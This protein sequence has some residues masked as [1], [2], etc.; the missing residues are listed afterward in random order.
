MDYLTFQLPIGKVVPL[1]KIGEG[2]SGTVLNAHYVKPDG[3]IS[4]RVALKI[5]HFYKRLEL[6]NEIKMLQVVSSCNQVQ[7]LLCFGPDPNNIYWMLI[8][9]PVGLSL[10]FLV[11]LNGNFSID[12]TIKVTV[13]I[14]KA[15]KC[16]HSLNIIHRDIKPGNIICGRYD[17]KYYLIDFGIAGFVDVEDNCSNYGTPYFSPAVF[18]NYPKYSFSEDIQS[19]FFCVAFLVLGFIPWHSDFLVSMKISKANFYG[20]YYRLFEQS[21]EKYELNQTYFI[22]FLH[23]LINDNKNNHDITD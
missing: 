14:L 18:K 5:T 6:E 15:L 16:I 1:Y 7:K 13:D 2:S 17:K 3:T 11:Q 19:L 21:I 10:D 9:E 8:T 23:K 22:S 20:I 12:E 4:E